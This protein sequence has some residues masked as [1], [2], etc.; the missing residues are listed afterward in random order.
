MIF[1][2]LAFVSTPMNVDVFDS[3][4]DNRWEGEREEEKEK[5]DKTKR[6]ERTKRKEEEKPRAPAAPKVGRL[7]LD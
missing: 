4:H 5:E 7:L 6:E 2:S 1:T 3:M